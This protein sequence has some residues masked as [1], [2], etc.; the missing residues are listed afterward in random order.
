VA[1]D[2][3]LRRLPITSEEGAA[4]VE[5]LARETLWALE[6]RGLT[7]GQE[8]PV[9][10]QRAVD[11]DATRRALVAHG[12]LHF[13]RRPQHAHVNLRRLVLVALC[14]TW[15]CAIRALAQASNPPSRHIRSEPSN[16]CDVSETQPAA[17]S[18][19][20]PCKGLQ[21]SDG[22]A[23][24]AGDSLKAAHSRFDGF[25]FPC[26]GV[27]GGGGASGWDI[28]GDPAAADMPA[29]G[30]AGVSS[31]STASQPAPFGGPWNSRPK[32]TGDWGGLREQLRD[33]GFTFD[34]SATTYYQGTASGG[35]QDTFRFGGRNDYLLN[36]DGQK[37]G[38]WPGLFINL[39]GETVYGDSVNLSTGAVVPVNIGRSLP[40]ID[41]TVT[42]L[43]AVKFAQALSENLVLYAGKINTIDNL[44]Q[45]FMPGRG[46]DAGFMNGAFV[47]N[48][49]LGRTIPYSTFGAGAAIL[50]D[51]QPLVTLTVYDTHDAST[52]SVFDQLFDNGA[53]IY[54]TVSLP[55]KFFHIPPRLVVKP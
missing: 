45:P 1:E 43:T 17:S 48:P 3:W 53:I 5:T 55:T 4:F 39:H 34:I 25:D 14:L 44:Q 16:H 54:P 28:V 24:P 30:E 8:H 26:N 32:L 20:S 42:A 47:F 51:G 46:L 29:D 15:T 23:P 49:V 33:H 13:K 11:R 27:R 52:T 7:P 9:L 21:L 6:E 50:A 36:V 40:R 38:L 41:G 19:C 18:S 10:K 37:A 12:I 35:L 2:A 31:S 22:V